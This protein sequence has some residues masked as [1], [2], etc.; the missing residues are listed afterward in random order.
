MRFELRHIRAFVFV[1][2]ELHFRRAAER[3]FTTQP[4]LSRTIRWLEKEVGAQLFLRTT[5]RVE[6]TE[7]GTAFLKECYEA[8][9]GLERGARS[10][11]SAAA[12]ETGHVTVAYMDFA[13]NGPLPRILEAFR[14]RH[15]GVR[16]DLIYMPTVK[17]KEALLAGSIDVGLLIGP[18]QSNKITAVSVV[19]DQVV[20]LMPSAHPLA[21][22]VS[23][24]LID[25]A[26]EPFILGSEDGW[27]PFRRIVFDLCHQSGFSPNIAQEASTSDGILGLVAAGIGVSL[28]ASCVRNIHREGLVVRPLAGI[29]CDIETLAAWRSDAISSSIKQFT[30]TLYEYAR[31]SRV[32]NW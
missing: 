12:G 3:L 2:E 26:H 11:R 9:E 18:F 23:I 7:A 1:A 27:T 15:P 13:I 16:V 32:E 10:A 4:G 24:S 20:V 14:R 22:L 28:Y 25:L 31:L 8:L 17:Q 29:E 21:E 5:R 19:R 6:L 30:E